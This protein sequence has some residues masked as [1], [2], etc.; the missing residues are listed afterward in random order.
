M[1]IAWIKEI[2]N[3]HPKGSLEITCDDGGRHPRIGDKEYGRDE[4][5]VVNAKPADKDYSSVKP[6]NLAVPWSFNLANKLRINTNVE[7]LKGSATVE[8][9]GESGW[10]YMVIRDEEMR[11]MEHIDAGSQGDAPGV[12]HSW[13]VLSLHS[14]GDVEF[15]SI[16]R[17]GV[18]RDEALSLGLF[19]INFTVDL[20]NSAIKAIKVIKGKKSKDKKKDDK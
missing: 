15:H 11:E 10:D 12:N 1:A 13:W 6:E 14:D 7:G 18:L 8:I 5:I 17:Q 19:F 20:T 4:A 16:E 2:R 3:Y 9:R